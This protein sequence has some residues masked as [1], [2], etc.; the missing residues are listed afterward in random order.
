[1]STQPINPRSPIDFNSA[2]M[3]VNDV[4]RT[5]TNHLISALA[6]LATIIVIAPL[7]AIL[8]YLIYKG[9][10]SLN[11]AFF[12]HIPAPVGEVGGGMSNAIVGSSIVLAL[13]SLMGIPIGISAGVYLS[14]FG[15]GTFLA[16]AV[17]FTA[18][19]LNGVPS[20]VMGISIY[21]LIVLPQN[22]FSAL[23]GGV[24]LGIMMIPTVTRTTE[25][26]LATVP[27][28][29]REAALG[30]GIPKW[31]TA[32]SVSLR[33]ASPGIITGCMLAFAR[34]AGETAPLLFTAFGNQF[35]SFKL[36]EPIA[37]LPLQIYVYAISPYDEWHR[38]AWAGSLVLIVLIMVSVTLVRIFANRGVLKG[39]S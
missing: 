39:N 27:H 11:L 10:S 9:A 30:L 2:S 8:G 18:D 26:M 31:R 4:R 6:I 3:R 5:A 33:T 1:M 7:I 22:H 37:A 28:A 35:W 14:E 32:I 34:V 24:V 13:A 12:T 15:R 23:S 20:I 17:R 29:I 25:E 21:S 16:N 36:N 19:V 38:L